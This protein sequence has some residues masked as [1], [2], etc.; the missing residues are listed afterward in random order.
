MSDLNEDIFE[1]QAQ[2]LHLSRSYQEDILDEVYRVDTSQPVNNLYNDF[3]KY[4]IASNQEDGKEY[5]AI[6]FEKFYNPPLQLLHTLKTFHFNGLNNL[7]TYGVVT[8]S[9]YKEE[10]L[11]AIVEKYDVFYSLTNYTQKNGPLSLDQVEKRLIPTFIDIFIQCEKHG[12]NCGNINPNNIII[13]NDN[14]MLREFFIS[15]ANFEQSPYY[16]APELV[17]CAEYGR[18][19]KGVAVDIYAFGVVTLQALIGKQPWAN[20]E[21]IIDYNS[22]RL[23]QTSFRFLIGKRKISESLKS[24]FKWTLNDNPFARWRARNIIE[25]LGGVHNKTAYEKLVDNANLIAF[26][27]QNYGNLKSLAYALYNNWEDALKFIQE[28]KLL[29]WAQRQQAGA[30]IIEGIQEIL[31]KDNLS[32]AI[33]KINSFENNHKLTRLLSVIDP[34]GGIRMNG[35]A[36]SVD[37]IPNAL[38]YLL[39]KGRVAAIENIIVILK[40]KYW[41]VSDNKNSASQTDAAAHSA[42]VEAYE[43]FAPP[44]PSSGLEMLVYTLNPQA[45]CLSGLISE[46]YVGSLAELLASLN[47]MAANSPDKFNIDRH[48]IA[49]MSAKIGLKNDSGIKLLKNFPKFSDHPLIFGLAILN[50]ASNQEPEIKRQDLC[51]VLVDKIIAL[52]GEYLHNVKFKKQLETRLRELASNGDLSDIVG[53]LSDQGPFIA[54]YNGYYNACREAQ[55]IKT[56]IQSLSAHDKYSDDALILGQKLTVLVSYMLCLIVTVI[57]MV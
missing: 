38:H 2:A 56:Y 47:T 48:I 11:V 35:F 55:N 16:L 52:F 45:T 18:V 21:N 27:G 23:E 31:G 19:T 24:F 46:D 5:F 40:E 51:K 39:I 28:D 29:K 50:I 15:Y 42:L 6:V 26:N 54:D 14:F 22:D 8:L 36:I 49:Y 7:I 17:E 30:E 41:K 12:V 13:R 34:G 37:S 9:E 3:C 57:L 25:W 43:T 10:R 33:L 53:L 44:S 20:Y 4:Y 1:R 32:K